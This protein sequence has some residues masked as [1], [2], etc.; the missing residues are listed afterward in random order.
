MGYS[1]RRELYKNILIYYLK[2]LNLVPSILNTLKNR[3]DQN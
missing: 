1:L 2:I 3:I